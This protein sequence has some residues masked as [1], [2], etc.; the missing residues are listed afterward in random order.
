MT[1]LAHWDDVATRR[2]EAGSIRG[3][4][5]DLGR[6]AGMADASVKR[7][8]V[9]PGCRPTPAHA[10]GSDEEFFFVLSG[11]GLSWQDGVTHEV[12]P[13]D[14]VLHRPAEHAHTMVAGDE[15]LD[16]LVFGPDTKTSLTRLPRAGVLR[17]GPW[18]LADDGGQTRAFQREPAHI[19]G[20]PGDRPS[21]TAN[22]RDVPEEEQ[23]HGATLV[24]DRDLGRFLGSTSTGMGFQT[25]AAGHEG[26]PPHVHSAE[27][28]IFVVLSGS[29]EALLGE[30]SFPVRAGSV[31]GRP[32]GSR[33]AHSF[34][35]GDSDLTL[36][37]WGTREANDM[38]YYPRSSK[39]ALRG[40]GVR[41]RVEHL[42]EY[43][44][45]EPEG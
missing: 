25:I 13:G 15:G 36:L 29:G 28:E 12:G 8:R 43:W 4:W 5:Q 31:V 26:W 9:D 38:T 6:A 27:H 39:V 17:A 34:V 35:A 11:N 33:V 20:T 44:D 18:L 30:E 16:V 24:R 32:A 1:F 3:V 45:G 7:I 41:F 22:V 21:T 42:P 2:V 19:D 40:L 23:R 37:A 10:H 14:C